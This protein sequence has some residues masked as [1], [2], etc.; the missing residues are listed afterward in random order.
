MIDPWKVEL[1]RYRSMSQNQRVRWL[2]CLM[3]F[4]SMFARDTYSVGTEG[5]DKPEDLRKYNEL[6]HRIAAHQLNTT[7]DNARGV[8]D[9]DFFSGIAAATAEL[10]IRSNYLLNLM[11]KHA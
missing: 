4:V 7:D 11:R 9:E 5:L 8:P 10:S 2:S 6:I 3:Y 1:E